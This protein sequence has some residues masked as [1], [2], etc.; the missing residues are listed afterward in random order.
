MNSFVRL[1]LAIFLVF[2][3]QYMLFPVLPVVLADELEI[4]IASAGKISLILTAGMILGGPFYN[5]LIDTYKRKRLCVLSFSVIL[6]IFVGYYFLNK[7]VELFVLPLLQGVFLGILISSLLTIGID[8]IPSEK[9]DS[10][11]L[12]LGWMSRL[13]MIS[14]V[15]LGSLIYLNYSFQTVVVVAIGIGIIAL[16]FLTSIRV[17]FRAPIGVSI[18]SLDRFF[19]PGSWVLFINMILIAFIIGILFPLIHFKTGDLFL[20]EGWTVPYFAITIVGYLSSLAFAKLSFNNNIWKQIVI[21]LLLIVIAISLFILFDQPVIQI[22]SAFMLG[23]AFGLITP[24]LLFMFINLS[25][26]CQRSTA[27]ITC[28]LAWEIGVAVGIAVSCYLY[29]QSNSGLAYQL[30]MFSGAFALILFV[31]VSSPYYKKKMQ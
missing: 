31:T 30:A 15:A 7:P 18:L 28:W 8:I 2:I 25:R 26:H 11:N 3:S 1:S 27:N 22:V 4:S 17:S 21:S 10:G 16:L 19:L 13:G 9:R 14:G 20:L 5:Y 23:L 6:L 12:V 29:T 24:A